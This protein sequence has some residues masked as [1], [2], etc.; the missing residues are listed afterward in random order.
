MNLVVKK[1]TSEESL[2]VCLCDRANVKKKQNHHLTREAINIYNCGFSSSKIM[3]H[4]LTRL[5]FA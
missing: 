2:F 3:K 4:H 1:V 5:R